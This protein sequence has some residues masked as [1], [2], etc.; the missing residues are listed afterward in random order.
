MISSEHYTV[1]D[2]RVEHDTWPPTEW[3][4]VKF[5]RKTLKLV[6]IIDEID[7]VAYLKTA[8]FVDKKTV[9]AYQDLGGIVYG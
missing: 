1:L 8:F 7:E 5:G 9:K 2:T 3:I 4:L 6:F